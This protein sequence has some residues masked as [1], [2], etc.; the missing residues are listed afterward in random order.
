MDLS[1]ILSKVLEAVLIALLPPLAVALL[2]FIIGHARKVWAE[3]KMTSPSTAEYLEAA[4]Q[5]AVIAAEQLGIAGLMEEKKSYAIEVAQAYLA[6][7][8][9]KNI[10]V[11]LISAAIERAVYQEFHSD[12]DYFAG[13]PGVGN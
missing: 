12:N 8:G 1:A 7:A 11:A 3:F 10:D 4:A 2:S 5:F 13:F 9:V 6:Q